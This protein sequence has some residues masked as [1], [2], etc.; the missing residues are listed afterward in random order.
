LLFL[1]AKETAMLLESLEALRRETKLLDQKLQPLEDKEFALEQTKRQLHN[2]SQRNRK[3]HR[4][5]CRIRPMV[6]ASESMISVE[7][8]KLSVTHL[9]KNKSEEFGSFEF[10]RI[11]S[12]DQDDLI[13]ESCVDDV[14]SAFY[15]EQILMIGAGVSGSGKSQCL[16]DIILPRSF[17]L[18]CS[19]ALNAEDFGWYYTFHL[20]VYEVVGK[21]VRKEIIRDLLLTG[22]EERKSSEAISSVEV[23]SKSEKDLLNI[24]QKAIDLRSS[25]RSCLVCKITIEGENRRGHHLLGSLSFAD[26]AGSE[27]TLGPFIFDDPAGESLL[28]FSSS[29]KDAFDPEFNESMLVDL[30]QPSTQSKITSLCCIT[31]DLKQNDHVWRFLQGFVTD[32]RAIN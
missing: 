4:M 1:V 11:M 5:L 16:L 10:D 12:Q 32:M 25:P 24:V 31:T 30:L 13:F 23:T 7:G 21:A 15:G 20:S 2:V 17:N 22:G 28:L 14:K 9:R 3:R 26:F 6:P 18:M 8:N 29:A 19:M 27:S